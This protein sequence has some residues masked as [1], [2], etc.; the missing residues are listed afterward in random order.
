M[1]KNF[2]EKKIFDEKG[3]LA[4]YYDSGLN[5]FTRG[6]TIWNTVT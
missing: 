1:K 2:D 5:I 3:K 6:V 4:H